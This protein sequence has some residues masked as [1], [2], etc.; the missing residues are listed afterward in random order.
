MSFSQLL[1]G[2]PQARRLASGDPTVARVVCDSRQVMPGDLFVAVAG[3]VADG[4]RFL[5]DA[6][7]RGAVAVIVERP[8]AAPAGVPSACVDD[9]RMAIARLAHLMVGNPT[10]KLTV[11]GITGTNGKTTT[12]FLV[13]AILDA[14]GHRTGLLGTISYQIGRRDLPANNTTPGPVDLANYFAEMVREGYDAAV[15]EVSSH[16][17][18]Q[19]RVAGIDFR[20]AA[21][22]NLT[23]EHLDYHHDL[24]TYRAAKGLLFAGLSR[25]A[26]AV[27]NRDDA[28]SQTFADATPARRIVWYSSTG[29]AEVCATD[30]VLTMRGSRF[31]LHLGD[32]AVPVALA[33]IGGHNVTNALT[34]AGT[35]WALGLAPETIVAGLEAVKAVPGRLEPVECGQPFAV[36]VDFAHTDDALENCLRAARPLAKG[37]LIA[38]FGCGG[39]RDR[40]K[41]PRMARVAER[42]ADLVVVTN[43]NP[44]TEQPE[45]IADEIFTG[46]ERPAAVVRQLDRAA[47]IRQAVALAKAGD[48]I[49]LAGKG[50]EPYQII[51]TTKHDFD[52]RR[53]AREALVA[54]GYGGC[55][56]GDTR[57]K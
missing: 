45:A 56:A 25:D 51:G 7:T 13:R 53:E 47:A 6:V 43:D 24:A 4:H 14:A 52:D 46:F 12:T 39:D 16:A 10:E 44:R 30:V 36:L 33:L 5:A 57:C 34:A 19:R 1:T 48:V 29:P 54:L 55:A 31:M 2:L 50:H 26:A 23:P 40:T 17:L 32:A 38:V 21:F 41:R 49:V 18:D 28:A 37:R 42:L 3:S 15:M 35:A 9:G 20:V 22:T 8:E 27:L 11:C